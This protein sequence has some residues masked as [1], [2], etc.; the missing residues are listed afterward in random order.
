MCKIIEKEQSVF[1]REAFRNART[2]AVEDAEG[3]QE[4][5]YTIE[6]LGF[7]LEEFSKLSHLSFIRFHTR[8]PAIIPERIDQPFLELINSY[9]ERF[10]FSRPMSK[11]LLRE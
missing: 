11:R 7:Y 10:T 3:F 9:S 8:M 6:K 4:I 1:F 5:L 2:K